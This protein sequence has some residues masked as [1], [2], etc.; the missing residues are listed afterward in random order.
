V[1]L[2]GVRSAPPA[3]NSTWAA[4]ADVSRVIG[5]LEFTATGFGSRVRDPVQAVD[6]GPDRFRLVNAV[7]PQ[8]VWGAEVIARY[9]I[10]E[11]SIVGTYAWTRATELDLVRV[12][13]RE[14]PL[15]PRHA[16]TFTAIRESE[17]WGRL[18][19]EAYYTGRQA[20]DE[21]PYRASSRAYVLVGMLGERR[22]G[23]YRLFLNAENLGNVRQTKYAPLVRP[24]RRPDGRWTVD[25][26]APLDGVVVNGGLRILVG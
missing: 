23:R 20:L 11:A 19:V 7:E 4:S 22:F 2:S 12:G 10:A 8:W 26:W 6:V 14:T 1:F 9:R 16:V 24:V 13:R 25:A 3:S 15:T 5:P 17:A 21:D 18:G